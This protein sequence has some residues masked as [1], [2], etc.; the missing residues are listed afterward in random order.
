MTPV[1]T[2]G[3]GGWNRL[4][5][6]LNFGIF[7]WPGIFSC[8]IQIPHSLFRDVRADKTLYNLLLRASGDRVLCRSSGNHSLKISSLG[9]SAILTLFKSQKVLML[10][11]FW[12]V[13][14]NWRQCFVISKEIFDGIGIRRNW[15]EF[16]TVCEFQAVTTDFFLMWNEIFDGNR[17]NL[18]P[19]KAS[20]IVS[21][22]LSIIY[23]SLS[24]N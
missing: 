13:M 3:N 22:N 11:K 17:E 4:T 7:S 12:A 20:P 1:W 18:L 2:L 23:W 9:K 8:G 15:R 10:C 5:A 21:L 14:S 16:V 19:T 24:K 6:C